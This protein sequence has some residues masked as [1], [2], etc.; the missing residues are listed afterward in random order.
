M[1]SSLKGLG[2]LQSVCLILNKLHRHVVRNV[3]HMQCCHHIM[4]VG[5]FVQLIGLT[6]PLS[7]DLL[8]SNLLPVFCEKAKED[9]LFLWLTRN[10]TR[11]LGSKKNA[12]NEL[13]FT[14]NSVLIYHCR[15]I[16]MIWIIR[17]RHIFDIHIVKR[18]KSDT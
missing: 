2:S 4:W 11:I 5:L 12:N 10:K 13:L 9:R 14:I 8:Y 17:K 18:M 3:I 1:K 16:H 15:V 7:P 6:L